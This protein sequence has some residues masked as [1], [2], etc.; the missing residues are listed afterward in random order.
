MA[1]TVVLAN[2]TELYTSQSTLPSFTRS[3][4]P[5]RKLKTET[6]LLNNYFSNCCT[7]I[8]CATQLVEP[9]FLPVLH[10]MDRGVL[11]SYSTTKSVKINSSPT[12]PSLVNSNK[13]S[14]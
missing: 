13:D 9:F 4:P 12:N 11:S 6:A 7:C 14:N 3:G 5:P 1:G 2:F 8:P 10:I